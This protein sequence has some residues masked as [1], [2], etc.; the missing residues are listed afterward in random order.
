M[1]PS[2]NKG[3]IVFLVPYP[4][5]TIGGQR[6][7]FEQY[8]EILNAAGY[9]FQV[10]PFLTASTM[11]VLYQPNALHIKVSSVLLGF[12]KRLSHV[13][14][15]RHAS[16]IFIYREA[17]P[18]GPPVFEWILARVLKRKLIYDFDDAIWLPDEKKNWAF[19]LVKC[20][21]KAR[22]ICGWSAQISAGNKY[23]AA[24]ATR[25]SKSVTINPTTIDM[26]HHCVLQK[27]KNKAQKIII[28]WTG[29]HSTLKYLTGLE[30]VLAHL[31]KK[32]N[33]IEFL[34]IADRAPRLSIGFQFLKWNLQTEIVDLAKID[35]GMMPLSDD[36]WT[37]G[38]CGFKALQYMAME[39]A[40]IASP[41]GVNSEI[42]HHLENGLL[43]STHE[44][45]LMAFEQLINDPNLRA[46]I[47]KSGRSTVQQ[48]Y[49]VTSNEEN[50]LSLFKG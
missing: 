30:P 34:V 35:I 2:K 16:F 19:D 27:E 42:I 29:S 9:E 46:R 3:K 21:W 48:H 4:L 49:S 47:G 40:T 44:E 6:F 13:F 5:G 23:L 18:F 22:S 12:V 39:I 50:F 28:G 17:A 10:F 26:R 11:R 37:R 24:F 8:L 25:F 45:W 32:Y 14:R 41:V 31:Q 33:N 43:A 36:D 20:R 1:S 15:A 38:K 7:R